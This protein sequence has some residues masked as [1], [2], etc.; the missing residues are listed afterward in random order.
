[1]ILHLVTIKLQ[2]PLKQ[3]SQVRILDPHF[4]SI[5]NLNTM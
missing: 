5:R 2:R 3:H 4:S 1:M